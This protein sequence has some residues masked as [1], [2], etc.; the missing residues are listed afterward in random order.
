LRII[1]QIDLSVLHNIAILC[2]QTTG[3]IAYFFVKYSNL[4]LA[5]T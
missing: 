5:L 1:P 2:V 4:I 3:S